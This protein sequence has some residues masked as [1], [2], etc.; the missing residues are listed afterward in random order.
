MVHKLKSF[1]EYL[2][3][4]PIPK[5]WADNIFKQSFKKIIEYA[6]K[7]AKRIASG[8]SRT[9][10]EIMYEGRPTVL[11]IAKNRKGLAQ[12]YIE[13]DWSLYKWYPDITVPLIDKDEEYDEPRW[14]HIEKASK[15]T[16]TQFK[17]LTGFDFKLFGKLLM[18]NQKTSWMHD[19]PKGEG[20]D[21]IKESELFNNIIDLAGNFDMPL[22]DFT[23]I[24]NWGLYNNHPV[25]VDLGFTNSV[26]AE[27]Y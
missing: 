21:E 3:E 15:I 17:S 25:L 6:N 9:V 24:T 10:F 12:N 23:R 20:I 7:N 5:E 4:M 1:K 13:G 2:I 11:K 14:L 16:E 26:R 22:G 19:T 8:S 27:F 18:N